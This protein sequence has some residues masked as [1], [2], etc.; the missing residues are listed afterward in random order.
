MQELFEARAEGGDVV[1]DRA[2]RC[3]AIRAMQDVRRP[4]LHAAQGGGLLEG[5]RKASKR[6]PWRSPG[7]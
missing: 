2:S 4:P 6:P 1:I 3:G 5:R 7:W